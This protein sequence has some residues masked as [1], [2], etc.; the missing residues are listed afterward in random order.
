MV[1]LRR[2][3]IPSTLMKKFELCYG[4]DEET[5]LIPELLEVQEPTFDFNYDSSLKF[6]LE[7]EF[8]PRSVMPRFIVNM[9]EDIKGELRWRTGVVLE[10]K[11]F[12]STAVVKADHEAKRMYIYVNGRQKRDYFAAVLV[13]LR[14]INQSF[15]KMESHR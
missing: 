1:V 10:D 4:I 2:G 13:N 3:R 7:Y 14:R 12:Q 6:I 8:L 15:E 9:H 11:E 5:V